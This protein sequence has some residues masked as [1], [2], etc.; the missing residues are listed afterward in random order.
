MA[1]GQTHAAFKI[2]TEKARFF[3]GPFS[4][5]IRGY[6]NRSSE[7]ERHGKNDLNNTPLPF[8]QGDK[9]EACFLRPS[10]YQAFPQ[11]PVIPDLIRNPLL[12]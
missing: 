4:I 5:G 6:N 2:D 11:Q 1:A 9:I 10:P 3:I 8:H 12:L 7:F